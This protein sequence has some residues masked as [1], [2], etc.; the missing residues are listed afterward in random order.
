MLTLKKWWLVSF[1]I[2]P[3]CQQIPCKEQKRRRFTLR[4]HKYEIW[5]YTVVFPQAGV[6]SWELFSAVEQYMFGTVC[7]CLKIN[8]K[9][10]S[11]GNSVAHWCDFYSFLTKPGVCI[12]D[13]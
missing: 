10:N 11:K 1:C 7:Y 9:C 8:Y 2:F 13:D 3:Y 5:K 12:T 4:T 6:N